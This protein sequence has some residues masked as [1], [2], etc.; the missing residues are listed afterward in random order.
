M[1][2]IN[3]VTTQK[4]ITL[5]VILPNPRDA[6]LFSNRLT[7][8]NSIQSFNMSKSLNPQLPL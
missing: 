8:N 2:T 5:P 3:G 4:T 7:K 1:T 6:M